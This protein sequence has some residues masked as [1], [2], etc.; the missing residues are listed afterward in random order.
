MLADW[1]KRFPGRIESIATSIGSVAPS[2][3][4][5]AKLFGFRELTASGV[6]DAGGDIAFDEEPCAV[7]SGT[8]ADAIVNVAAPMRALM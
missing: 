6:A 8:T 3:L 1:E 5:D 4:M 2:H 7:P